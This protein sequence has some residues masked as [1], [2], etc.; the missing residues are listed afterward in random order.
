MYKATAVRSSYTGEDVVDLCWAS[1]GSG[2]V[3]ASNDMTCMFWEP[4]A[5]S[6]KARLRL[7]GH[8]LYVQGVAWD[9]L[10]HFIV[11]QGADR[12]CRYAT[13]TNGHS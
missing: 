8:R 2:F 10:N 12:S 6:S 13:R 11:S 1:D 5:K 3:T 4:Q 9:P 7:E